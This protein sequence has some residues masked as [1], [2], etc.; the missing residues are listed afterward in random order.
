MQTFRKLAMQAPIAKLK[1]PNMQK[2]GRSM[3]ADYSIFVRATG[4]Q[5]FATLIFVACP[6]SSTASAS[7]AANANSVVRVSF[8]T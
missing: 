7:F 8:F 2:Y 5:A 6:L 4:T 3:S 1:N